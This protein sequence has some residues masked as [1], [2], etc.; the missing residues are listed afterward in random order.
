M[1][2]EERD[3]G[4]ENLF[5]E[6]L[7]ENEMAAGGSL[8]GHFM[9][10][11]GRREFLRFNLARPNIWYAGTLAVAGIT[12]AG[13]LLFNNPDSQTIINSAGPGNIL[14]VVTADSSDL[15]RTVTDTGDVT[16]SRDTFTAESSRGVDTAVK[17]A[18]PAST[19]KTDQGTVK[20]VT[21]VKG[22][23]TSN[24]RPAHRAS[25]IDASATTG[26]VPLSVSF[27]NPNP[28][29]G[30]ALWNFGDGGTATG[31]H[32]DYVYD[33]PGTYNVTLTITDD[34]GHISMAGLAVEVFERPKA[35]FEI[36]DSETIEDGEKMVFTNNSEGA[37]KYLWKFGDGTSSSDRDVSHQYKT[38]GNY[39]VRL[40][41]WSDK[42]CVDSV[43]LTDAYT[44]KGMYIRFPNAFMP[45]KGGPTGGFYDR[46]T[47]ENNQVF[48]PVASGVTTY[49][50]KIYSKEGMLVFETDQIEIGWDGYCKGTLC[51]PGVYVWKVRGTYRN[52]Q[53]FVMAG[54]VTLLTY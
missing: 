37:V 31:D 14:P 1:I 44:D 6:K 41:A 38:F 22:N 39:D 18:S 12:V 53:P 26:C 30:T 27:R 23:N 24:S 29:A 28:D 51:S 54:D 10:R 8:S 21:S 25:G 49:N 11:L 52:G 32:P 36:R 3:L 9:R 5:R 50:L 19:G 16:I 33:V 17:T 2:E 42:G 46:K 13:I 45:D 48:H 34:N 7:G 35:S 15:Q 43:T 4:L 47:D 20:P 40:F